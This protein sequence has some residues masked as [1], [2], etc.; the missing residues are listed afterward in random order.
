[1]AK[2]PLLQQGATGQD[3]RDVQ[4]TLIQNGLLPAGSADGVFGAETE[5]AVVAYQTKR[6]LKLHDGL[7]GAETWS[8]MLSADGTYFALPPGDP[9]TIANAT[10]PVSAQA[11]SSSLQPT[12]ATSNQV[13]GPTSYQPLPPDTSTADG[14]IMANSVTSA[15]YKGSSLQTSLTPDAGAKLAAL[16]QSN[17]SLY[18]QVHDKLAGLIGSAGPVDSA[19]SQGIFDKAM[20]Y[21]ESC[22]TGKAELA[23]FKRIGGTIQFL[24]QDQIKAQGG[25]PN[26]TGSTF[27]GSD[28]KMKIIMNADAALNYAPKQLA[29]AIGHE[30]GHGTTY[31]TFEELGKKDS[32][33][34]D[35]WTETMAA[36]FQARVANEINLSTESTDGGAAYQPGQPPKSPED[37]A[38]I[39]RSS[40]FYSKYYGLDKNRNPPLEWPLSVAGKYAEQQLGLP[41]S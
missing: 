1:V 40:D 13:L 39:I 20:S 21:L 26:A 2:R 38:R 27:R 16:K 10:K 3:V 35:V 11:T 8:A 9:A 5:K 32:K 34:A 19:T 22:P 12:P 31:S 36:Q 23:E 17:P 24:P 15:T 7:V 28:G 14:W 41:A 30:L 6:H 18:S 25:D 29:A 37:T 33:E 4:N